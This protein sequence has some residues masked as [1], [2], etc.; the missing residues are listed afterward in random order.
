MT[1][2]RPA[3]RATRSAAAGRPR[4]LHRRLPGARVLANGAVLYWWAE[5]AFVA[6]YYAVYSAIRNLNEGT[7]ATARHHALQIIGFQRAVGINAEHQLQHWALGFRPLIIMCNYFYGSL[8][9]VVTAGVLI[10][11]FHR[12]RDDYPLWRNT[13]AV[14]TGLALIG[15]IFYP[16]MP[17]RLLPEHYGFVDTLEKD[18]AFWSFSSGAVN[19][20]SNQFAA[21]PS[22]H[23]AWALWC[24]CALVPRL[25]RR[26][27]QV[28]AAVYPVVTVT[29]IV[30]T[31]NH[32]FVDAL[33]G[34]AVFGIG[35][36]VARAT[37]RA[38]RRPQAAAA[39]GPP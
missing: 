10:Y 19:K 9:F 32:Y 23:C 7:T 16:L 17:P 31:A 24:A 5:V 27:A 6:V 26:W 3:T 36:V 28:L 25:R 34:F 2:A 22:V 29:A 13:L 15:F 37:T 30:L 11:L 18:P 14:A 38:G 1:V 20:V 39:A 21:M 8:H 12:W 33:A 4:R 35:Y